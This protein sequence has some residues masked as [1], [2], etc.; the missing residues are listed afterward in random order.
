[1][2]GITFAEDPS[3][4]DPRF[5]RTRVRRELLPLLEDLSPRIVE[6]LSALSGMLHAE[7]PAAGEPDPPLLLGRAQRLALERAR[8][9][10]RPLLLR[11]RGGREFALGFPAGEPVATEGDATPAGAP[12][13]TSSV[14]KREE[15]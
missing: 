10:G 2:H 11:I 6:H 1:R 14:K 13:A 9:L 7:L 5:L 4:Q 8:K 12:G 15:S 3:N